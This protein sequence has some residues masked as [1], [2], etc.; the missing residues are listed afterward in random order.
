MK[1]N[2]GDQAFQGDVSV[3]ATTIPDEIKLK[4]MP[5]MTIHQ[6]EQSNHFHVAVAERDSEILFSEPDADGKIY[7]RVVKGE[8]LLQHLKMPTRTKADHDTIT[9]PIGD[10]V[11]GSQYEYDE[12]EERR[13]ID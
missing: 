2:K 9:I 4:K 1:F 10:Y 13:V 3:I 6:G 11:F 8:A 12:I 7:M 5:E